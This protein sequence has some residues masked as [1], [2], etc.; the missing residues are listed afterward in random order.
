M[1]TTSC[2]Y[3]CKICILLAL[4]VV[5]F[6]KICVLLLLVFFNNRVRRF[7]PNSTKASISTDKLVRVGVA[8]P[9]SNLALISHGC[10]FVHARLNNFCGEHK[11]HAHKHNH[12]LTR[13]P[14]FFL[15]ASRWTLGKILFKTIYSEE[16]KTFNFP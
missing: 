8:V 13:I 2:C 7:S 16:I 1:Q 11:E 10:S 4:W 5:S 6:P 12:E 15:R 3:F 9:I 14:L